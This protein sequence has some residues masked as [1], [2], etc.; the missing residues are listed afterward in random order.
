MPITR[1][2][3]FPDVLEISAGVS[4]C[5][6]NGKIHQKPPQISRRFA[7]NKLKSIRWSLDILIHLHVMTIILVHC[8]INFDKKQ[9]VSCEITTNIW[10]N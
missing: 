6:S 9:I 3:D 8:T 7:W 1:M 5:N 4:Y 2:S 10:P